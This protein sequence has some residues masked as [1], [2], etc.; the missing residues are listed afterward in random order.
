M[1]ILPFKIIINGFYVFLNIYIYIDDRGV[2]VK[3]YGSMTLSEWRG[4]SEYI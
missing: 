2:M 3:G 4:D 1:Y